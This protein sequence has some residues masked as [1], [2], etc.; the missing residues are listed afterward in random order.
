MKY[1]TCPARKDPSMR[2]ASGKKAPIPKTSKEEP[3]VAMKVMRSP[4][5]ISPLITR[6]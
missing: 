2:V 6:T 3:L 1:P 4:F 5:L